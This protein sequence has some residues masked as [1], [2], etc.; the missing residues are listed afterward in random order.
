MAEMTK[1][2]YVKE[3]LAAKGLK[4]TAA[5]RKKLGSEYDQKY[6]GGASSDWRSRF[7]TEFPQFSE[8]VDG[9]EGETK[10]RQE[11]GDDLIDLFLDYA[12][13]PDK[14]DLT[15]QAGKDVW[16]SKVRATNLY[17]KVAPSRREWTLTPEATKREMVDA[18]KT[19][20]LQEYGELELN[21]R[22]LVDL[23]TYAL[24]TK[25]SAAQTKYYAYSIVAGRKATPGGPV[26]LE[27]TDEAM[28]LTTALKRYNY[29]PPG[30]QEQINSALTGNPYLGVNYTSELLLKKAKDNAKIM[31]PHF[32]QQ[33]DQGYTLDD[34]FEPYK[35]IA[36]QTLELNPNDIKYTDP[37]FR[38]ALEKK[39]DGTSMN[40]SEWEYML[41][42][43]PKYKWANTKKAKE[44]ASSMISILEKA[45][46]QYI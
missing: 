11:F 23:A 43:D 36:A 29:N 45:F 42:K 16:V 21:D 6:T 5:N 14:Y 24:S 7:K 2:Q 28:A 12:K 39:P 19:E 10:A 9:A 4:N 13:N 27:E 20:L 46:G 33:F 25:A 44:Q 18:K 31:M 26:A 1:D 34:V 17:T 15:T 32:A 37:K 41:K 35:E 38:I 22:Q 3:Q 8:L 30:L 40:A